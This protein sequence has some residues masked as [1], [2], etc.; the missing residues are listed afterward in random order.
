MGTSGGM[1][2]AED[3]SPGE[4]GGHPTPTS[5]FPSRRHR[6]VDRQPQRRAS[7]GQ[8]LASKPRT[9][10]GQSSTR[11]GVTPQSNAKVFKIVGLEEWREE[12]RRIE[13]NRKEAMRIM[14]EE[15]ERARRG[16]ERRVTVPQVPL[17]GLSKAK[18]ESER[19]RG[20]GAQSVTP[21]HVPPKGPTKAKIRVLV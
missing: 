20:G 9:P 1:Q 18:E 12:Q 7:M 3:A 10:R 4:R 17:K 11:A 2:Q 14:K 8:K 16:G 13:E 6:H 19:A 15:S 5:R 21:P